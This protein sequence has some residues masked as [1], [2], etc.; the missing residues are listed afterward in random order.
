MPSLPVGEQA[1][2]HQTSLVPRHDVA[3]TKT[4]REDGFFSTISQRQN[5]AAHANPALV[6][7]VRSVSQ[8]IGY[9]SL[10]NRVR[11]VVAGS[12]AL[13]VRLR[14]MNTEEVTIPV[15]MASPS[16]LR[17][18]KAWHVSDGVQVAVGQDLYD[19]EEAGQMILVESFTDGFI[20][21]LVG[22]GEQVEAGQPVAEI[23]RDD[24]PR[25][26]VTLLVDL[27]PEEQDW[28]DAQRGSL[29]RRGWVSIF[30]RNAIQAAK[31][32]GEQGVDLNT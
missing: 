19:L 14:I 3:Q 9:Y 30:V 18:L 12:V 8:L 23:I 10:F 22:A 16:E 7:V 2:Y 4:S 31:E 11:F 15:I 32:K 27:M 25:K 26:N 6:G 17:V 24:R 5:K 21:L 28:I 29:D 13:G 1:T 20:K